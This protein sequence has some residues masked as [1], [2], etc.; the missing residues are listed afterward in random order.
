MDYLSISSCP[1]DEDAAQ[2][3][4]DPEFDKKN[5]AECQRFIELIRK[6]LGVEPPGA[7]LVI[8]ANYHD[9]GTYREVNVRYDESSSEAFHYA[10]LVEACAPQTWD[11]SP[12][13][14]RERAEQ[15]KRDVASI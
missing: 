13:V 4:K 2:L 10:L 12:L 11:E 6:N 1:S 9:F 7:A 5:R 15:W 8:K 3:G 14:T